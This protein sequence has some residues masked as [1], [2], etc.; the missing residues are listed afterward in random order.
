MTQFESKY[1]SE[2]SE[3]AYKLCLLG[4]RN[5]DLAKF[6]GINTKTIYNWQATIEEFAEALRQGKE[7]ADAAVAESL[8]KRALGY[9]YTSQKV[10]LNKSTKLH[11]TVEYEA[12]QPSDTVACIFWLKNRRPDLWR[13]VRQ[14]ELG[15]AGDFAALSDEELRERAASE[16]EAL[17]FD[18]FANKVRSGALVT[19]I[20]KPEEEITIVPAEQS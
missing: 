20:D 2:Y 14:H 7:H 17:G 6:F 3:Q 13:D 1:K 18:D 5:E 11:E 16:V 19:Y 10:V 9:N 4:A 8:F 12:H 15:R